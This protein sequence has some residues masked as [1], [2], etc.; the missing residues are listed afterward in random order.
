MSK[1]GMNHSIG[2]GLSFGLTSG[3]ITT[4]GL[5]VGL[6]SGTHSELAVIGGVL[7][8]A[9]ADSVSDA[10]GIHMSEESEGKHSAKEIWMST[11]SAF[12]AKFIF[13]LTFVV[14]LL[15]LPLDTAVKVSIVWGLLVITGLSI[16]VAKKQG[17]SP[18]TAVAEHI[19]ITVLV[20]VLTHFVG[21][22]IASVFGTV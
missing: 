9:I 2:V 18:L 3:I 17:S 8:I 19:G 21:G 13:A 22:W 16:F 5:M 14:P 11:I 7:T 12:L 1:K 10:L 15:L 20:L 6:N 4:M